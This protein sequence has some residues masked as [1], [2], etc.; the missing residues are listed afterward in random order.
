[1]PGPCHVYARDMDLTALINDC[2]CLKVRTASRAVT[3]IYDDAFRPVGLRATQLS[4]LVAVAFGEAVSIASLSRLLGMDRS[5]LTRNLRPLEE[6]GLVA[7]GP[8]GHHRSRT[9][10]ITARGEQLVRKAMPL[11]EKIQEKV[12]EELKK[13]HWTNLHAELDHVIKSVEAL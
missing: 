11:W 7:L 2:V 12:R 3:R 1:M 10:S 6:K 9:L 8:E 5:T 13:P 4:V